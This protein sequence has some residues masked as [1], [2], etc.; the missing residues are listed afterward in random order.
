MNLTEREAWLTIAEWWGDP[1]SRYPNEWVSR[2]GC[3]GLCISISRLEGAGWI[4][5]GQEKQMDAKLERYFYECGFRAHWW[6]LFTR[7]G[8]DERCLAALFM[9]EVE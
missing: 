5:K 4:T 7:D 9:L 3:A 6:D 8:A 1:S 2:E